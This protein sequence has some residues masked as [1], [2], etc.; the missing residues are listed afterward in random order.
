MMLF[1]FF[2]YMMPKQKFYIQLQRKSC[3]GYI[4]PRSCES[5]EQKCT[6]KT[7]KS[8]EDT[9]IQTIDIYRM[10]ICNKKAEK[11]CNKTFIENLDVGC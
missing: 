2:I 8:Y 4:F 3:R 11:S 5:W 7:A 1:K 9:I 10:Y 6:L